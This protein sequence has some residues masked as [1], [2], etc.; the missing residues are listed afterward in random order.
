[1]TGSEENIDTSGERRPADTPSRVDKGESVTDAERYLRKVCERSFLSLWS[2]PAVFR[3]QKANGKGDGKEVADVLVVFED[4]VIVFSDKDI[5]LDDVADLAVAWSRWHRRAV[6]EGAKQLWGA[7]RWIRQHPDKLFLDRSCTKPFPYPLPSPGRARF[8]LVLVAHGASVACHKRMGGSGSLMLVPELGASGAQP[9]AVGDLD[10]A[11][12]FV[13]VLDDTSLDIVMRHC[14]TISDFV[15]YLRKK[16]AFL[17]GDR[18]VFAAGEEELLAV[19]LKDMNSSGEHDFVIEGDAN[20]IAI[21]EGQYESFKKNKQLLRKLAA[22]EP[23]YAWD[24]LIEEFSHNVMAGTLHESSSSGVPL[25]E[26]GLRLMAREPRV[27]RRMLAKA[28]LDMM[29]SPNGNAQRRVRVLKATEPRHP[30]YVFMALARPGE[31]EYEKYRAFR[32]IHLLSYCRVVRLLNE[33]ARTVV[34]IATDF[35]EVRERSEDLIIYDGTDFSEAE[36]AEAVRVR[37]EMNLLNEIREIRGHE[38][39]Y[40]DAPPGVAHERTRR[41]AKY[42][43]TGRNEKCPC[44]SGKKHKKCCG[45]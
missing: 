1:V 29:M 25:H 43:G 13:H 14:D 34:G 7:E 16:E 41:S 6:V 38:S 17:R 8:H 12:T 37:E 20:F 31:I 3:N 30:Y 22:D 11:R 23:S 5:R 4:D 26:Q 27:R 21:A 2:Y 9:F 28:L 15:A 19:Y 44:G 32:R 33:D 40:P 18:K 36:R 10:P 39:E 42:P 35:A 45:A 24:G